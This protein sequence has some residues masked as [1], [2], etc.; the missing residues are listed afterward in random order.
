MLIVFTEK[1]IGYSKYIHALNYIGL[2]QGTKDMIT[3][4]SRVSSGVYL[5]R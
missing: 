1:D 4:E 2:A 5:P 3:I